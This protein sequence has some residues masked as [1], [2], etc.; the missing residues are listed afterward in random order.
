MKYLKQI[1]MMLLAGGL[2]VACKGNENTKTEE[3]TKAKDLASQE[4]TLDQKH[5]L[6]F[7]ATA[8][9]H[10]FSFRDSITYYLQ[11]A[12]DAGVTDVVV[13]VKPITGEVLYPSKIAPVMT[14]WKGE[15]ESGK[16]DTSWDMLS[17]FIKEG[18]QLGLTI[19]ASTNVFVAGHN[20]FDRGVV[21]EDA[22]KA[23][24]QTLSY[25]P[26][27]MTLITDQKQKYSA[28]L[29]PALP[30]VQ[31]YQLSILKELVEMYPDLDGLVLD[32][33][34][35]DGI[36]ADFSQAS[37]ELFEEYIEQKV[38]NFPADIFSYSS[39]EKPKRIE[40]PLFKKWLEWR[41]KVIH[42]FMYKAKEVVTSVNP[43]LIYGDYTGSWYPTYYEVG[44]N[45]ASREYDP[46]GD[47][48]WATS[49]YKNYGYSE[50][51]DVFLT[52]NYFFEVNR[53]EAENIN[54]Q[55]VVRNEAGQGLGKE[56]WYT[57]EG[58]AELVNKI[59]SDKTD[60]FAGVYV[61]QYKKDPEQFVKALKMCRAK[62]KGA[63]VF[64]IVHVINY[65]WWDYLKR[66]LKE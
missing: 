32:R 6:Y 13:D 65:G 30:E 7:D 57:V 37:K 3:G 52:G 17:A 27:G 24:W 14:E 9:F 50:V 48:E 1:L 16:K 39:G 44:V 22:S 42:D 46:S 12:K 31:E 10:R 60:V 59:V 62:S 41:A 63:M 53:S 23:H 47:F 28:M 20:Y 25:L 36:Q 35:Y 19:H 4:N 21:Y 40:G 11:K 66:G 29:N 2:L 45:W 5:F 26:E 56:Y 49:E 38:E 15:Y 51:L 33:V 55:T 54:T 8:N 18:H 34:R 43:D 61:E 58:S 64:D